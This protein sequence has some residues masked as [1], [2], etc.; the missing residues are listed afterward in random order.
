MEDAIIY[1]EGKFGTYTGKTANG[2]VRYSRRFRILGVIDS[3]NAGRDAGE[4]LDG[5]RNGIPI[6]G[7]FEEALANQP[8]ARYFIIGVATIGGLLPQEYREVVVKAIKSGMNI[9]SGLHEYLSEDAEL[10]ALASAHGVKLID[11]RKPKPLKEMH[12]FRNLSRNL[13]CLRIPVLGTDG[14]IGKR[15]TALIL[16]DDLNRAGIRAVFVATGQTGLMQGS[17]YGV[18]LDAIR[19]DYMVGE[20]ESEIVRAYEEQK[21]D[22]IVVEGQGSIS[23]PAYVCGTR[24][25]IMASQ[26]S[27]I[28]CQHAPKRQ[29]RNFGKDTLKLPM[30]DLRKE[31]TMLE[32]F[33]DAKVIAITL[34]H[35]NMSKEEIELWV[36]NY[37]RDFGLPCCD[38]LVHG[39]AKIVEVIRGMLRKTP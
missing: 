15:T 12:Q 14:S 17:Q 24:A 3:R 35:E 21:P 37:E 28:V 9:V 26:P 20:L 36:K 29:Y 1:C 6:Y 32:M 38:A 18:P 30:P 13:P 5:K 19:G 10:S 16:T 2:L 39:T 34:N 23:H 27:G 25:I 11:V 33:S 22:V 7:S 31:I 4:V 8:G